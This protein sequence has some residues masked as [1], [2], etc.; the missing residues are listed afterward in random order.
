M[1]EKST[2]AAF[3]SGMV[4]IT[5][6]PNS[7]QETSYNRYPMLSFV[8]TELMIHAAFLLCTMIPSWDCTLTLIY[9]KLIE[10]HI[11]LIDNLYTHSAD[12]EECTSE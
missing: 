8:M 10:I 11:Q 6:K 1:G 4:A 5:V 12:P 7:G 2:C 3:A 9:C